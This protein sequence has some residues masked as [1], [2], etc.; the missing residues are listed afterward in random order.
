MFFFLFY[1]PAWN[2][3]KIDPVTGFVDY[4]KPK[5]TSMSEAKTFFSKFRSIVYNAEKDWFEF[6]FDYSDFTE[7]AEGTRT[8]WSLCTHGALRY[9]FNHSLNKG[10]GGY[11]KCNVTE[12]LKALFTENGI[13]YRQGDLRFAITAQNSVAFY[14]SLMKCL[15]IT[16]AMRYS[17]T[18]DKK[19]FIL[20]PVADKNGVFYC[21]EGREDGLPQDADAN[22]AFNIARK[23]LW[24]LEQIGKSKKYTD[25]TTKIS[26][27]DWIYSVQTHGV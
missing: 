1:V 20:S 8:A 6:S 24:V 27:R 10:R 13:D 18:E 2:T 25:W 16:L 17:S 11:E 7:K 23:G 14:A 3:S 15:Q 9:A 26:N 5:Y 19:D 21:S 12:K 22:G 4:L